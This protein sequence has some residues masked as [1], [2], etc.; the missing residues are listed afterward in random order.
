MEKM[1]LWLSNRQQLVA[2]IILLSIEGAAALYTV[3]GTRLF[4]FFENIFKET[5]YAMGKITGLSKE[6]KM[7]TTMTTGCFTLFRSR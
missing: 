6:K 7:T 5:R 3:K 4:K 1:P 2:N